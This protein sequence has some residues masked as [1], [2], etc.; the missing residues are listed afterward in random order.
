MS[1]MAPPGKGQ[2][3]CRHT[4]HRAG[5]GHR[6]G[7]SSTSAER[8]HLIEAG[9]DLVL[10][11]WQAHEAGLRRRRA[12]DPRDVIE[13]LENETALGQGQAGGQGLGVRGQGLGPG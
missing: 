8:L 7:D 12:V 2:A 5:W 10:L 9:V 3:V 4:G 1:L 11:S 13:H 6:V